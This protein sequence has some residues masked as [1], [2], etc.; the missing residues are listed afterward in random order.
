MECTCSVGSIICGNGSARS[1]FLLCGGSAKSTLR[2]SE[3]DGVGEGCL[4]LFLR[5]GNGYPEFLVGWSN[6]RVT[7]KYMK[8]SWKKCFRVKVFV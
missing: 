8:M 6:G 7:G 3:E 1:V 4:K 2:V 5:N